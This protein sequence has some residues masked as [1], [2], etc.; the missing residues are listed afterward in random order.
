M[1]NEVSCH[2]GKGNSGNTRTMFTVPPQQGKPKSAEDRAKTHFGRGNENETTGW[3]KPRWEEPQK[4]QK[5]STN[6]TSNVERLLGA[7]RGIRGGG[8]YAASNVIIRNTR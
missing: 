6:C 1:S 3:A 7:E 2:L 8:W 5:S 4:I